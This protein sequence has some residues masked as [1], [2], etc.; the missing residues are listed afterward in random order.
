M[1]DIDSTPEL[2]IRAERWNDIDGCWKRNGLPVY[3]R[4]VKERH[5]A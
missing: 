5:V 2:M 3:P 1:G 4:K